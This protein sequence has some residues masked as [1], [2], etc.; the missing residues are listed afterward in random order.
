MIKFTKQLKQ[1]FKLPL[2]ILSLLAVIASIG[3]SDI[4][5]KPLSYQ[6]KILAFGDS[7]TFG[8]GSTKNNT[9]PDVLARLTGLEV[10][11]AGISGELSGQGAARLPSVL[12]DDKIELMILLHGG[13]DILRNKSMVKTK[14]SLATMI[15]FAQQRDIQVVLVGVPE[16][17]LFAGTADI[18]E[19][20]AEEYQLVYADD[21]VTELIRQREMKSDTV[22]F[23]DRG[24]QLLAEH[25]FELLVQHQIL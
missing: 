2:L 25:I 20:L 7:L 1:T 9:Y 11:N 22:H 5:V 8:K 18:Y 14:Q 21:I 15:E 12:N 19:Q 10:I 3:C 4:Q 6:A 17:R 24:Y 13:N 16:K 23:N